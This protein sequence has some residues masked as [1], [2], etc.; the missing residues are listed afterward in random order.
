MIYGLKTDKKPQI[1]EKE[2]AEAMYGT[3]VIN[4]IKELLEFLSLN[5]IKL[6]VLSNSML[7]TEEVKRE[8]AQFNLDKYFIEIISTAD[9]L[10]RKP[11]LDIFNMYIKKL[12]VQG[13][14]KNDITYIGNSYDYDIKSISE[15][16]NSYYFDL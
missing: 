10:F 16:F 5:N 6:Y 15:R 7:S 11:S 3:S 1:I 13:F 9:Y 8:I 12:E 14:S 4:G 2:F